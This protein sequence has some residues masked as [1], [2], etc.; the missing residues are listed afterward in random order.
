MMN[1]TV[2]VL[3]PAD[4]LHNCGFLIEKDKLFR[5][6]LHSRIFRTN[7]SSITI[8]PHDHS[9]VDTGFMLCPCPHPCHVFWIPLCVTQMLC[10]VNTSTWTGFI[11]FVSMT[12]ELCLCHLL[13]IEEFPTGRIFK[14]CYN[15]CTI[16]QTSVLT[17]DFRL[18]LYWGL[19]ETVTVGNSD[20]TLEISSFFCEGTINIEII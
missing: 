17:V 3:T 18:R 15:A 6:I 8:S 13:L 9:S 2:K 1:L 7:D 19:F 20:T 11:Q 5:C 14:E 16:I 10:G 4:Y 12:T